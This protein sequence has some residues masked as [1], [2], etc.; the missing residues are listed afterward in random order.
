MHTVLEVNLEP[1]L[2]ILWTQNL[3]H[4]RRA[5]TLGRLSVERQVHLDWDGWITEC[6]MAGLA[7]FVVGEGKRHIGCAIKAELP[8]R[9]AIFNR[10]E[11]GSQPCCRGIGL[12]MS[13]RSEGRV[14]GQSCHPHIQTTERN[15]AQ[16]A[17]PLPQRFDVTDGL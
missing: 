6:Q 13:E 12:S 10:L 15:T 3:I 9:L 8:V 1:W 4:A 17:K 14:P 16:E 7:F 11:T 2:F 5:V